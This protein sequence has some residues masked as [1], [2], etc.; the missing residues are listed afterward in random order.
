MIRLI[1]SGV[2]CSGKTTRSRFA[3]LLLKSLGFNVEYREEGIRKCPYPIN[4][5]GSYRSQKWIVEFYAK[6]DLVDSDADYIVMDRCSIDTIP[7]TLYL[8]DKGR[9]T[10]EECDELVSRSKEIYYQMSG[11]KIIF[12]CEPLPMI[13]DGFRSINEEYRDYLVT[14]FEYALSFIPD[15]IIRIR[16]DV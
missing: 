15:K 4:E 10:K 7:Y 8:Y 5:M 6:R 11:K 14:K 2:Q 12:Y 3:Y 16:S 9:M 1:F 13:D